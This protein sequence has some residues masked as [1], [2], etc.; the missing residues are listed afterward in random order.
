[1]D[2]ITV[3]G[4]AAA[5]ST[6]QNVTST[7]EGVV[8]DLAPVVAAAVPGAA[9]IVAGVEAAEGVANA[10]EGNLAHHTAVSDVAVGLSALAASPVVQTNPVAASKVLL[11]AALFG[12]LASFF[13][14]L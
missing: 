14:G 6:Q 11:L 8:N 10:V 9:P 4:G 2:T 5:P 7:V 12:D 3:T 1:M 13:K